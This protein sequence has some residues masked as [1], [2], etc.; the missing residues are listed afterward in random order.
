MNKNHKDREEIKIDI[1]NKNNALDSFEND[2]ILWEAIIEGKTFDYSLIKNSKDEVI[3]DIENT[4]KQ[5]EL[6]KNL[7]NTLMLQITN[8][9]EIISKYTEN[10]KKHKKLINLQEQ[11]QL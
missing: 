5:I 4:I 8:N 6:L 10:I 2:I 11:Q 3:I 1:S 9:N 7:N